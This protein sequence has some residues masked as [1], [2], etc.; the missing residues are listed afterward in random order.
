MSC[1]NQ[2]LTFCSS[3]RLLSWH[4][5][6]LLESAT[7]PRRT[8]SQGSGS[9]ASYQRKRVRDIDRAHGR[10]KIIR[11][12]GLGFVA[13][14]LKRT[15]QKVCHLNTLLSNHPIHVSFPSCNLFCAMTGLFVF[16]PVLVV[17]VIYTAMVNAQQPSATYVVA[18]HGLRSGHP[19]LLITV[20]SSWHAL[21][22]MAAR[23]LLRT[24]KVAYSSAVIPKGASAITTLYVPQLPPLASYLKLALQDT[25]KP[26]FGDSDCPPHALQTCNRRRDNIV[27]VVK[28]RAEARA[29][30]PRTSQPEFMAERNTL[31]KKKRASSN[32]A[33]WSVPNSLSVTFQTHPWLWKKSLNRRGLVQGTTSFTTGPSDQI[34]TW[35][36]NLC[37]C[38]IFL[39]R[40]LVFMFRFCSASCS[41]IVHRMS[42]L[43]PNT[44]YEPP[45]TTVTYI[46]FSWHIVY[47]EIL[48]S[49]QIVLHQHISMLS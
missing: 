43:N 23:S 33:K 13:V 30:N 24:K 40:T 37:L 31:G 15:I 49:H 27:G 5:Y 47:V 38:D 22:G 19:W 44:L 36:A 9:L 41:S 45:S 11:T 39:S 3:L 28:R 32:V 6:T 10:V 1:S 46:T 18:A 7:L 17:L 26:F 12:D 14:V 48:S 25:G 4:P 16:I 35:L 42:R 20:A 21:H 2:F 29:A 8:W 34:I